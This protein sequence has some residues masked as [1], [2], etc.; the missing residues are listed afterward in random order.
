MDRFEEEAMEMDL[1]S[2]F[3]ASA[4][5]MLK[6]YQDLMLGHSRTFFNYPI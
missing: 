6:K 4:W 3:R 5:G 2:A 1:G